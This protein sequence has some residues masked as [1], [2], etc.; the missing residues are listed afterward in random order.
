MPATAMLR[1]GLANN[2]DGRLVKF[3]RRFV[4]PACSNSVYR[5]KHQNKDDRAL[6]VVLS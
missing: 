3:G 1:L 2:P 4:E 5:R 6:D